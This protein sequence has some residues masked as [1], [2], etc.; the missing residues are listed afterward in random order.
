MDK[1]QAIKET[2]LSCYCV[3]L[4]GIQ[5]DLL[6]FILQSIVNET[7][8]VDGKKFNFG[9]DTPPSSHFRMIAWGL[10]IH[11]KSLNLHNV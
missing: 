2:D 11:L 10:L 7:L 1:L 5:I 8:I 3:S 4:T 9:F 6:T